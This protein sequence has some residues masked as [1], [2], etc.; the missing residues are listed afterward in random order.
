M[1]DAELYR[2]D[3]VIRWLDATDGRLKRAGGR[4]PRPVPTALPRL[5]RRAASA[6]E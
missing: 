6:A 2:L 5:R 4:P 1:V 3:A